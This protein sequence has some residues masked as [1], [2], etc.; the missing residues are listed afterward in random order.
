MDIKKIENFENIIKEGSLEQDS[1]LLASKIFLESTEEENE[2]LIKILKKCILELFSSLE[3][4]N[5][6]LAFFYVSNDIIYKAKNQNLN[7]ENKFKKLFLD[8]FPSFEKFSE[9]LISTKNLKK[10][11]AVLKIWKEKKIMDEL[12]VNNCISL[13]NDKINKKKEYS[14][15]TNLN[16]D[17]EDLL[18]FAE[19]N[20]NLKN[21]NQKLEENL[22]K[23]NKFKILND[24]NPENEINDNSIKVCQQK[25]SL[26]E[27]KFEEDK[28]LIKENLQTDILKLVFNIQEIDKEIENIKYSI[29][30]Q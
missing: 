7:L 30:G 28:K 12:I 5:N 6:L 14:K 3:K 19:R 11:L 9:I 27:K 23:K 26:L 22:E 13:I 2:E 16:F 25:I 10:I 17:I 8:I 4:N 21:W 24:S 15:I 20:K 29:T 1:I 18:N